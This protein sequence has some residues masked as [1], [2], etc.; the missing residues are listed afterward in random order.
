MLNKDVAD[1]GDLIRVIDPVWDWLKKG[2]I[3]VILGLKKVILVLFLFAKNGQMLM[4]LVQKKYSNT[5][6]GCDSPQ[7]IKQGF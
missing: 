3:G 7:P 2:D 4:N 6:I 1:V 5:I